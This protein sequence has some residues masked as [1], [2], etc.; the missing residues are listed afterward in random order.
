[1]KMETVVIFL[2]GVIVGLVLAIFGGWN[3]FEPI[4]GMATLSVSAVI[5]NRQRVIERQLGDSME[6][7]KF[8]ITFGLR[9]GYDGEGVDFTLAEARNVINEWMT[10]RVSKN[11]PILSGMVSEATLIYPVRNEADG[12][13]I[14]E[15]V[16]GQ[17]SG[18]LSPKY[19]KGRSDIEVIET[20]NNLA[21]YLGVR[22][23]QERVYVSF[24][25]KQ[26]VVDWQTLS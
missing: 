3:F 5:W 1:M 23:Q 17:Y 10:E 18:S 21:Y 4:I 16:S 7:K 19:D 11:L 20:L 9:A 12:S 26:W 13:R 25:G 24:A 6:H 2:T 14:T 22:L 8:E 15:E